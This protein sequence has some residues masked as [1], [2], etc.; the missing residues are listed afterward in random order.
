MAPAAE[1]AGVPQV[2]RC[3]DKGAAIPVIKDM[4]RPDSTFLFKASRGMAL[5]ELV[6]Y[7]KQITA[8]E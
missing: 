2:F 7:F 1:L 3:P 4:V 6:D 8:E 5:E